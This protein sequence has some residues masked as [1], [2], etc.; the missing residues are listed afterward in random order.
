MNRK[1]F[2]VGIFLIIVAGGLL[3]FKKADSP[4]Q[5]NKPLPVEKAT[6]EKPNIILVIIETF[7]VDHIGCYGYSR[8]TTPFIDRFAEESVLF[9][10]MI[11]ASSWTMPSHMS[12][13][14]GI[15]PSVHKATDYGKKLDEQ[16]VTLAEVL[17]KNGYRTAGFISNPTLEAK[18]GFAQGFDFYDD[19]TVDMDLGFNLFEDQD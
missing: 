4:V 14:T 16:I 5:A 2:V 12:M 18:Y 19:F 3:V 10:N 7:R 17:R 11:S 1:I 6:V 13:L 9:K 8:N 15:Y